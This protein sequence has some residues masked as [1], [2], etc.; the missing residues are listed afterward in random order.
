MWEADWRELVPVAWRIF[1]EVFAAQAERAR[2]MDW[3]A[4][5]AHVA[6]RDWD[7]AIALLARAGRVEAVAA[8]RAGTDYS[9]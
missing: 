7:A 9:T 4:L 8:L 1:G 3:A 2:R 6:A 5:D